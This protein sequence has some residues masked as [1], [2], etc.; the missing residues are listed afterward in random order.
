MRLAERRL[1]PTC[2]CG[3]PAPI[4]KRKCA[5]CLTSKRKVTKGR[6]SNRGRNKVGIAAHKPAKPYTRKAKRQNP[7]QGGPKDVTAYQWRHA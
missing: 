7:P 2:A 5:R 3:R 4:G 6:D 1:Y